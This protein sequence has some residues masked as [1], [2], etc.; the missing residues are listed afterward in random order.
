MF[1]GSFLWYNLRVYG[2][3]HAAW[4]PYFPYVTLVHLP[5]APAG[6]MVAE[7]PYGVL[8]NIPFVLLGLATLGLAGWRRLDASSRLGVFCA[9]VG[10][11]A[12]GTAVLTSS[13]AAATNRYMVDFLPA[14]VVLAAI[15]LQVVVAR[16]WYRGG[17]A[18]LGNGVLGGLLAYSALFNVLVSV[19]H[20]D[21]LRTQYPELYE[22]VAHFGNIPSSMLGRLRRKAYGPV[23]LKVIFPTNRLGKVEPLVVTGSEFL[24]DYLYVHYMDSSRVRFGL[25][26]TSRASL[27]GDP[28]R[29]TP[30]A[31]QTLCIDLSSLYPPAGHPYFDAMSEAEAKERQQ[32]VRVTVNGQ[33]ALNRTLTCYDASAWEPVIGSAPGRPAFTEPFSGRILSWRRLADAPLEMLYGPVRLRLTFPAFTGPRSEPLL[34]TGETGHG[35]LVYVHYDRPDQVRFGYDH[36]GS[37]GIVGAPITVDPQA[38]QVIEIESG[39]LEAEGKMGREPREITG[40][41]LVIRLNGEVVID[42]PTSFWTCD[43]AT[44]WPIENRIHASTAVDKFSGT[45]EPLERMPS[46]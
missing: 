17:L 27:V 31:V 36:W 29:I 16:P 33:V 26:H 41:H 10:L 6:F 38:L 3:A 13:F 30:G 14:F 32:T 40:Q 7:D 9:G 19:R 44:I 2:L 24:S 11:A 8:P 12:V 45:A 28:V 4:S 22:R 15:G 34:S 5:T 39:A 46:F 25:E 18:L 23:E 43:P 20:N 42:Q 37:S 1:G 21:L 35:D